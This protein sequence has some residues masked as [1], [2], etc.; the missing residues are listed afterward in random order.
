MHGQTIYPEPWRWGTGALVQ[1]D[2]LCT[3]THRYNGI[4]L[5]YDV[6]GINALV[7]DCQ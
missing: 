3:A 7:V 5:I 1:G 2:E 4:V 6:K